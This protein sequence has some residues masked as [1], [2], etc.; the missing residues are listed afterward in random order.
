M[1]GKYDVWQ[2]GIP[3]LIVGSKFPQHS[4]DG[5]IISLHQPVCLRVVGTGSTPPGLQ[6]MVN[7]R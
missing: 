1:I 4:F 7:L 5:T 3:V 2:M 6:L